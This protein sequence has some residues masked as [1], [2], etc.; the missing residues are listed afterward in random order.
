MIRFSAWL[1]V[2]GAILL[3][4]VETFV[5]WGRGAWWPNY[6]IVYLAAAVLL[7]AGL[8]MVFKISPGRRV[9]TGAWGFTGGVALVRFFD[10][11]GHSAL[12]GPDGQTLAAPEVVAAAGAMFC[13]AALG[14]AFAVMPERPRV[15]RIARDLLEDVD[16]AGSLVPD[17]DFLP[18][19]AAH[20]TSSI[21]VA[22]DRDIPQTVHRDHRADRVDRAARA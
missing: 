16:R 8:M 7:A 17:D 22:R 3:T 20:A 12:I 1:A 10:A 21:V 4:V 19:P 6:M 13:L 18:Q 14:F 5:S 11:V 2:V 15:P 9:L